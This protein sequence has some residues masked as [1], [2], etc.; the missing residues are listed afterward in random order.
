MCLIVTKVPV[1]LAGR[2]RHAETGTT[3][4]R[5]EV[6]YTHRSLETV[7]MPHLAGLHGEI[8]GPSRR[9]RE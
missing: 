5:E 9:Q 8:P 6:C 2:V 7:S 1:V 4:I 3:F